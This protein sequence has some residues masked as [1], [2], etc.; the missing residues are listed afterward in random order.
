ML[1]L[2]EFVIL[3]YRMRKAQVGWFKRKDKGLLEEAKRLEKILDAE[4]EKQTLRQQTL[5]GEQAS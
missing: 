3:V 1:T 2:D 5:F 4:I